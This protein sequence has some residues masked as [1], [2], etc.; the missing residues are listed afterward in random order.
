MIG[1]NKMKLR[2]KYLAS[3][4]AAIFAATVNASDIIEVENEI[5]LEDIK[6]R[7]LTSTT[8]DTPTLMAKSTV[9][10]AATTTT[11]DT[12]N[13]DI[14]VFYQNAY[15]AQYGDYDGYYHIEDQIASVNEAYETNDIDALITIRDVVQITSVEESLPYSTIYDDDGNFLADGGGTLSS[16]VILN[17]GYPEYDTYQ[18]WQADLVMVMRDKRSDSSALGAA[19]IGGEYSIIMSVNGDDDLI[20]ATHEIGHNM[21]GRH[22]IEDSPN[23]TPAYA[24]P[25]ECNDKDTVMTS[26]ISA[27]GN[28]NFYSSPD[29]TQGVDVCG[30]ED[31]ADNAR[32]VADNVS[33]AAARRD[34]VETVGSVSFD[35]ASYSI[36]ED[37]TLTVTL[38]RDGDLSNEATVKVYAKNDTAEWGQDYLEVYQLATFAANESSTSVSFTIVNDTLEEDTEMFTLSLKY[39]YTLTLGDISETTVYLSNVEN[40]GDAS[41]F[42]LSGPDSLSEGETGT[43]TVTRSGDAV[44]EVV[45]YAVSEQTDYYDA[46]TNEDFLAITEELYFAE[47]ETSKTFTLDAWEDYEDEIVEPLDLLISSDADVSYDVQALTVEIIDTNEG[48]EGEFDF[49]YNSSATEGDTFD[50]EVTRSEGFEGDV[51][52]DV[53]TSYS[54]GLSGETHSITIGD[55]ER[56]AVLSFDLANNSKE[57]D[58]Y[59]M[60]LSF[61]TDAEEA[62]LNETSGTVDIEDND[63][64]DNGGSMG[65]FILLM[66]LLVPFRRIKF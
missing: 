2:L 22:E 54:N 55:G 4:V 3:I 30:D 59:T 51:T 28:Y 14:V 36:Y 31:E 43:Y 13:I 25:S 17:E 46:S 48:T 52:I 40:T 1:E 24:H 11:D 62:V 60:T 39:P 12:A 5:T 10:T 61:S 45:I 19:S 66:G 49:L 35:A 7:S 26:T 18:Q 9:S 23:V 65:W 57:E 53:T 38:T 6:A 33:T 50:I 32:V 29:I 63:V 37:E 20:T 64:E 42:S 41:T 58:D 34:G 16:I 56:E 8:D 15:M 27:S 47:G 21:G 44:G